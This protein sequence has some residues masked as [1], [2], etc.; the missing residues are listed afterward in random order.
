MIFTSIIAVADGSTDEQARAAPTVSS[1]SIGGLIK[2]ITGVQRGWMARV[3]APLRLVETADLD[4]V[5]PVPCDAPWF[6][7]YVDAW[8]ARWVFEHLITEL[9]QHAGHADIIREA[10][11]GATMDELVGAAKGMQPQPWLTPWEP[12]SRGK[13]TCDGRRCATG[14]L[15]VCICGLAHFEDEFDQTSRSSQA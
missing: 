13:R 15:V 10:L 3:A 7:S 14:K 5:V 9:A 11:D 1:L 8:S 2:H 4:T 12:K 6:P